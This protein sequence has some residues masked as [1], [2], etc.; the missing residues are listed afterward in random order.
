M[1]T[2]QTVAFCDECGRGYILVNEDTAPHGCMDGRC[3]GQI[4]MLTTPEDGTDDDSSARSR[5]LSA[6]A[7]SDTYVRPFTKPAH[8]G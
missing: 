5:R 3:Q 1:S 6:L 7:A 8:V 2:M 4:R